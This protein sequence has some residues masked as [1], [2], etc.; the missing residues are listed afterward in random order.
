MT[1]SE[2]LFK[3]MVT[4]LR[5]E[6]STCQLSQ[7]GAGSL[8]GGCN[9]TA[10]IIIETGRQFS[11]NLDKKSFLW[12]T[13]ECRRGRQRN[14]ELWTKVSAFML[15]KETNEQGNWVQFGSSLMKETLSRQESCQTHRLTFW[16]TAALHFRFLSKVKYI[17][18]LDQF[19]FLYASELWITLELCR[20]HLNV[21]IFQNTKNQ[22]SK[23]WSESI[24]C[25]N[26]ITRP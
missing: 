25:W 4:T 2:S 7:R 16:D 13:N 24:A 22:T 11:F 10:A 3:A 9:G 20:Q 8:H 19:F 21:F 15:T 18:C 26:M 23:I 5:E 14:L 17:T 6:N 1:E 12:L